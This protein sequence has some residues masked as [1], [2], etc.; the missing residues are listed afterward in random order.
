MSE[1]DIR[2]SL[3]IIIDIREALKAEKKVL[4]GATEAQVAL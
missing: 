3:L 2:Y 4:E 1:H